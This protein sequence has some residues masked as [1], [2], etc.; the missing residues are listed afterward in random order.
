MLCMEQGCEGCGDWKLVLLLVLTRRD[1]TIWL[2]KFPFC[3][4]RFPTRE[5]TPFTT[6]PDL[7]QGL[8][9]RST[10]LQAC[11]STQQVFFLAKP[12]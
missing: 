2:A 3:Q 7:P 11:P 4:I 5:G 1:P 10:F 9:L 8:R 12:H 6:K